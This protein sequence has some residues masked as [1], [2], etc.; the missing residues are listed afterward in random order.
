MG[1]PKDVR[2]VSK[3]GMFVNELTDPWSA[4]L[5]LQ[6]H[7]VAMTEIDKNVDLSHRKASDEARSGFA[8]WKQQQQ[9]R[10]STGGYGHYRHGMSLLGALLVVR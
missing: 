9:S 5:H 8:C 1:V 10:H 2:L 7:H 3:G 4:M 6:Q